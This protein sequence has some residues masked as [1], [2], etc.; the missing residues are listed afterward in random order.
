MFD[1]HT[2]RPE[3]IGPQAI[4]NCTPADVR[5]MT[6]EYPHGIFSTGIHPWETAPFDPSPELER[7]AL[8]ALAAAAEHPEV[9]AIGEAGMDALRGA[10]RST[11]ERIFRAH[12]TL[13]ERLRKPLVIH[14]VKCHN[15]ILD[16]R[17][18]LA[19]ELSQPWIFHG[20][21][22]KPQ[23]ADRILASET[24]SSPVYISLG[25]HFNPATACAIPASRL[26][27]ETDGSALPIAEIISRIDAARGG[28]GISGRTLSP[29]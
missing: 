14:V 11:Q 4:F 13:S 16:I 24:E 26:L 8:S 25:E 17:K 27:A 21:R 2:H 3:N 6:R 7:E 28:Q 23:L 5:R 12:I 22:G 1:C 9:K 29:L 15:E 10:S 18:S 20:F 19:R